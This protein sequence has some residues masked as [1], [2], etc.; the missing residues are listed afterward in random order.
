MRRSFIQIREMKY[1]ASVYCVENK[2]GNSL[3]CTK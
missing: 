1:H 2:E 3:F